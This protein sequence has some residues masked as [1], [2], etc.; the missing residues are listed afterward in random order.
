[1]VARNILCQ[2]SVFYTEKLNFFKNVEDE[3]CYCRTNEVIDC[4]KFDYV[5]FAADSNKNTFYAIVEFCERNN[6][7]VDKI[8][9]KDIVKHNIYKPQEVLV[10]L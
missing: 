5:L 2:D 6:I 8:L 1:M 9:F 4:T 10:R 3:Y 7:L